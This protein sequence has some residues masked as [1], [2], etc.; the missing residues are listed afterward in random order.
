[1]LSELRLDGQLSPSVAQDC[2]PQHTAPVTEGSGHSLDP[3][4]SHS[5]LYGPAAAEQLHELPASQKSHSDMSGLGVW[6][7]KF[8]SLSQY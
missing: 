1:M 7:S 8:G 2:L 5:L 6:E 4:P 3:L